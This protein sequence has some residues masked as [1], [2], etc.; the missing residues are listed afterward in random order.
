ME[1]AVKVFLAIYR[2]EHWTTGNT[3]GFP[4]RP[5]TKTEAGPRQMDFFPPLAASN[6]KSKTPN[7]TAAKRLFLF[8]QISTRSLYYLSSKCIIFYD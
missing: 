2:L 5:K 8:W 1:S 4:A 7:Q 3:T 6:I